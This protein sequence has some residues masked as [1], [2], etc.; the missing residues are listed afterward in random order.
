MHRLKPDG[1]VQVAAALISRGEVEF[2]LDEFAWTDKVTWLC[3]SGFSEFGTKVILTVLVR[4]IA[5]INRFIYTKKNC[6]CN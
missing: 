6:Y 5:I 1:F 3:F 4:N 2:E